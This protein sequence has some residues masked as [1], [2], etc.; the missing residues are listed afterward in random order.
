MTKEG[1]ALELKELGKLG[2]KVRRAERL[3]D[4]LTELEVREEWANMSDADAADLLRYL[5]EI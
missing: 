3:L 4:A 5:A 2:I 1:T